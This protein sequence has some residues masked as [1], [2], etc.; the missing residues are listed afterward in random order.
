[1]SG[2][3][4]A[5]VL[6]VLAG[7]L[8]LTA[9]GDPPPEATVAPAASSSK[10]P[11]GAGLP[12]DMVAAVSAGRSSGVVS[13]H[14]ALGKPPVVGQAFSVDVA[15]VPHQDFTSVRAHFDSMDG[16][17]VTTGNAME[18]VTDVKLESVLK[19]QLVVLPAKEGV[20]TISATLET[21][22]PTEGT[23]S[24]VFSLPMVV[25]EQESQEPAPAASSPPAAAP[26]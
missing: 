7:G 3:R 13:V 24:R 5:I 22:S 20:Y 1:M 14:F 18:P 26:Q 16:L 17:T 25:S 15:I 9:C 10:T 11:K 6:T 23:V 12:P 21:E 2:M 8:L 19:H 4:R